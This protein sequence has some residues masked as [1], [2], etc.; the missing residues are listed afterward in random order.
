VRAAV[1]PLLAVL[2]VPAPAAATG[3]LTVYAGRFSADPWEDFFLDPG[4]VEFADAWLLAVAPSWRAA[5]PWPRLSLEVEGQ[6][7]RYVGDQRNWEVNALVA[8]RYRLTGGGAPVRS[9]LAFGLGP[10]WASRRPV[11][12]AEG[13]PAGKSYRLMTYWYAE[14]AAAP[15]AWG[16]WRMVLRL[17]HRSGA[18]G[19]VADHGGSNVP[20][21]GV[22]RR[23]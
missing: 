14:A 2:A 1:M 21:L 16:P 5:R 23:F 4:G 10:S 12:E 3:A 22:R 13:D 6:L 18:F 17:H 11:L 20:T 9:S 7:A 8:A 15:R 19:L